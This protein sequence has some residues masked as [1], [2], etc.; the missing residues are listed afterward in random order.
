MNDPQRAGGPVDLSGSLRALRK[1]AGMSQTTVTRKTSVSQ[2]QLSRIEAGDAIPTT[3]QT[4]ELA[5]AYGA[6]PDER[7]RLITAVAALSTQFIDSRVILQKGNTH[8][9]QKQFREA[10]ANAKLIR[11]Y[12][13]SMVFGVL[14]TRAYATAV[15][16]SHRQVVD[17]DDAATSVNSRMTRWELLTD[18][19]RHWRLIMHEA[20]LRWILRSPA[21][22]VEQIDRIAE[23]SRLPN[24]ELGIIRLDT[25]AQDT[26]PAHS[27]HVFDDESVT[28]GTETG[29]ALLSD[30]D[31][32]T[33]YR[34]LFGEVAGLAVYG[35]EVRQLLADLA[36]KYRAMPD[37]ADPKGPA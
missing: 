13:P 24:V 19:A 11:S 3:E 16:A 9:F 27:F 37:E 15:F 20:A 1:R 25:V 10:E 29:T 8:N 4:A 36:A 34:R 5:Q 31:H 7:D 18:P 21:L 14:Q 22:M 30:P 6:T 2:A 17:R 12:Q 33:F 26:A 23:A 28:F 35:D 32:V